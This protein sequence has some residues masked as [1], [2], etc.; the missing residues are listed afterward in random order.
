M[1]SSATRWPVIDE[2]HVIG[3]TMIGEPQNL[4]IA[5]KASWSVAEFFS[6]MAPISIPVF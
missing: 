6:R 2:G 3:I 1:L 4:I 5:D